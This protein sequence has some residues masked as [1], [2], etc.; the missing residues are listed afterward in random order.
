MATKIYVN[1]PVK[2]LQRSVRFFKAMGFGFNSQF[3]DDTAACMVIS[4]DIFAMLLTEAKFREF[5]RRPIADAS[6]M[7]EVLTCLSVESRR[8]VDELVNK[9][10]AQGGAEIRE[11][12]DHGSMYGRTFKDLDGHIWEI[13][14]MDQR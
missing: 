10:L 9:A 4:A 5:A 3:S 12:E 6:R 2:D 7:A 14:T 8:K 11:P 1:L 13:I